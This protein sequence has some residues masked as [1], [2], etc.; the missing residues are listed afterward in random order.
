VTDMTLRALV[1]KHL[2]KGYEEAM[3]WG[4]ITYQV[5]LKTCPQTYNGQPLIYVALASQKNHMAV[6]LT[7]I[8]S[9]AQGRAKFEQAYRAT[10]KRFDVGKSC[11]RFKQIDDL[12]LSLIGETVGSKGA[13][14]AGEDGGNE[15]RRKK[16]PAILSP[17]WRSAGLPIRRTA[18]SLMAGLSEGPPTDFQG[19]F[20]RTLLT[21][22]FALLVGLGSMTVTRAQDPVI[23]VYK[24]P[25]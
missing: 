6:H 13:D 22:M 14:Q 24:S 18:S 8:Y 5:P 1:R 2:P 19:A 11:V 10:G 16:A 3:N 12:P 23:E 25:T 9:S 7:G 17:S 15:T 4:M 20:M 21:A